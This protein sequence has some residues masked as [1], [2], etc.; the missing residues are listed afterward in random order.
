MA[1]ALGGEAARRRTLLGLAVPSLVFCG[2]YTRIHADDP[3]AKAKPAAENLPAPKAAPVEIGPALSNEVAV[4]RS[5]ALKKQP[6]LS[7]YR[8][9]LAAAQSRTAGI[10]GVNNLAS[11]IRRDLPARK[12][13]SAQGL[14]VAQAQLKQ[15]EYETLYAVTRNYFSVIYARTQLKIADEAL[16]DKDLG[17]Q[18]LKEISFEIAAAEKG[19]PDLKKWNA[20]QVDVLIESTRGRRIEAEIGI[21]RAYAALREAIGLE[22]DVPLTVAEDTLPALPPFRQTR[23][24]VIA[25]ALARRGEICQASAG[26][27]VT[28]LEIQAQN[29]VLLRPQT[30]TFASGSDLHVQ[31]IPQGLANGDYRPGAIGI[32]MPPSMSGSRATR[33]E[34]ACALN[35]RAHSV[36]EKTRH[37]ITLETEDAYSKWERA[38]AELEFF[39][40]AAKIAD[41]SA[42]AAGKLSPNSRDE[43]G[44]RP[45]LDDLINTRTRA[46]QLHLQVNQS[47]YEAW[48]GLIA[49]E[50][51]TAGGISAGFDGGALVGGTP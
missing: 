50:R 1:P 38:T 46:T 30:Q 12:Q 10:M 21:K 6:S 32:E 39:R 19:R 36:L 8:A 23:E 41:E 15:A 11:I 33:V 17:L 3:P 37:L 34:Q 27:E 18:R 14:L 26:I 5:L 7:A 28:S 25:L 49:L 4:L 43:Y 40:K 20:Q 31:P 16:N 9:S 35:T 47:H 13:Q 48:L 44:P 2:D 22:L 29:A 24:Q 51:V 45:T 42:K